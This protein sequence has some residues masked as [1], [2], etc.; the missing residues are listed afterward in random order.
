VIEENKIRKN[1]EPTSLSGKNKEI[2]NVITS[3][4]NYFRLRFI[5]QQKKVVF[6]LVVIWLLP[7]EASVKS[8][9]VDL[10]R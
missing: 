9:P 1:V 3:C 10:S 6:Q 7:L 5:H 2:M 4:T 8:K